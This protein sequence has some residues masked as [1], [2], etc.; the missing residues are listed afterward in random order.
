MV[1]ITDVA[2]H[3]HVSKMTV[4]RVLNHPEKVSPEIKAAVMEAI[5]TLGYVQNR[6]GRSLATKRHYAIAFVMLDKMDQVEPYFG[7]LILH[8]A[9]ELQHKG[10]TMSLHR[11]LD[12]TY[13]DVDGLL[14]S[15]ARP[16][17]VAQIKTM[18]L[19]TVSYGAHPE[20]YSV[21]IDNR[22]GTQ[23]ATQALFKGAYD[24]YLYLSI[25]MPDHFALDREAGFIAAAQDHAH[26]IVRLPNDEHLSE[27]YVRDALQLHEKLGIV[28]ATDR[29]ALGA[30]RAATH[31]DKAIP[32]DIGI[33]GFDGIFIHKLAE[34]EL[35]TIVQPLH[36]IAQEMVSLL[37]EQLDHPQQAPLTREIPPYFSQGKTSPIT[38]K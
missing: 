30:L 35:S 37:L 11:S 9:D 25:D 29:L 17:D 13:D 24:H 26:T 33:V 14:I 3:A 20:L 38:N 10:Y 22:A 32:N 4:S 6:A 5:E 23:L 18:P 1:S 21:D 15:G 7:N 12:D 34:L 28:A 36:E 8:I 16:H 31:L 2:K 27:R 19:P